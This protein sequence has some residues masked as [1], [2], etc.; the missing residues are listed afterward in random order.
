MRP[1]DVHHLGTPRVICC[2]RIGD[3]IVDPGP[4]SSHGTLLE[5]LGG[6][7]PRASSASGSYPVWVGRSNATD[8]PVWPLARL[9]R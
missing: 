1:I 7:A 6:E 3:V 8:R 2:H 4:E 9:R 5:A